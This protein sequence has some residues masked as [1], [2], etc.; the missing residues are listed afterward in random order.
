MMD[1][2]QLESLRMLYIEV[3]E[4]A[5]DIISL[6]P[7]VVID[8]VTGSTPE[9]PDKHVIPIKG[10]HMEEYIH[11]QKKLAQKTRKLLKQIDKMEKWIDCVEDSEL[12]TIF[13]LR[14]QKGKTWA[15]IGQSLGYD[16]RTVARKC[17]M[18]FEN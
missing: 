11:L 2:K 16:R 15:E 1:K 4:L 9:R 3:D 18:F 5:G 8:S 12:R 14:Y 10:I 13:R 17:D 7:K 6:K